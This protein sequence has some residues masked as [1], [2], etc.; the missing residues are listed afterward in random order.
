MNNESCVDINGIISALNNFNETMNKIRTSVQAIENYQKTIIPV[1]E[2]VAEIIKKL[3]YK[4]NK[5]IS[6]YITSYEL[7]ELSIPDSS[8]SFS[9]HDCVPQGPPI[10]EMAI[11]N[12][13]YNMNRYKNSKLIL[14]IKKKF[15]AF[16]EILIFD[17]LKDLIFNI[18][19]I[20]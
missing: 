16:I 12:F 6:K 10:K 20:R 3:I 7:R 5:I 15:P 19:G 17:I 9:S 2:R 18:L 4:I 13:K 14:I 8:V 11:E 1:L